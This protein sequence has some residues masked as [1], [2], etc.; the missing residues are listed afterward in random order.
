[1]VVQSSASENVSGKTQIVR[2]SD[3]VSTAFIACLLPLIFM[4]FS[5]QCIYGHVTIFI[6]VRVARPRVVGL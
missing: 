3:D 6:L 4:L 5:V 1:M 2:A